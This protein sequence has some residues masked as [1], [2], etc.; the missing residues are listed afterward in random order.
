MSADIV[1]D[2]HA[3]E[4]R[5]GLLETLM[6]RVYSWGRDHPWTGLAD[7]YGYPGYENLFLQIQVATVNRYERPSCDEDCV[8]EY[9]GSP[10]HF[11]QEFDEEAH[12][13]K[14]ITDDGR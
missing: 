5:I 4:D 7:A 8:D 11:D 14:D 12:E 9:C 6:E 2:L 10:R 1:D 3:A 13:W